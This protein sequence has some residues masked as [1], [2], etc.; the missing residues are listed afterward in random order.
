MIDHSPTYSQTSF[1]LVVFQ[2]EPNILYSLEAT[3]HLTGVPR[4]SLVIYCRA[5]LVQP[6]FQQPNG[7]MSFTDAAIYTVRRLE[8]LRAMHAD[9]LAWLNTIMELENEVEYLRSELRFHR[10]A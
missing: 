10:N 4:R 2:P 9:D 1:A 8:H 7:A 6:I 5:G 3:A